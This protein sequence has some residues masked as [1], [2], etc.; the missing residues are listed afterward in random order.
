MECPL[1][2]T[3]TTFQVCLKTVNGLGYTY[4]NLPAFFLRVVLEEKS[5]VIKL[6]GIHPLENMNVQTKLLST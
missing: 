4:S 6:C 5:G 2:D 1:K 3:F